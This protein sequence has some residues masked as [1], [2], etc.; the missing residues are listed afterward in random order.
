MTKKPLDKVTDAYK[1]LKGDDFAEKTQN[2]IHWIL[3][4]VRGSD[5]LDIGCSQGIV[6]ILLGREGKKVD[7]IDIAEESIEYALADLKK[8]HESVQ[9]NISFR[10]ANFATEELAGKAYDTILLTEVLEHFADPESL[11]DKVHMHLKENGA[12][13][14]TVPFGINDYY[15]HK[16]TYY[17]SGLEGQLSRL[18]LI[19]KVEYLGEWAGIVCRKDTNCKQ[20]DGSISREELIRLEQAFETKERKLLDRINHLRQT[21]DKQDKEISEWKSLY[22]HSIE[23]MGR[24]LTHIDEGVRKMESLPHLLEERRE[25]T[26]EFD[27][28]R[29]TM[30]ILRSELEAS[31][32]NEERLLQAQ[33]SSLKQAGTQGE[34]AADLEKRLR[35]V[36]RKYA[37]LKNSKLGAITLKYWKL[38]KKINGRA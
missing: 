34:T 10:V 22:I 16:R 1:G 29:R 23:T 2:R 17:Y 4:Q 9:E 32:K 3:R 30:D 13:I 15:D 28:L 6:P 7:G 20:E 26:S 12:L 25:D 21:I 11:L 24:Q 19:E 37:S 18:F 5:I 27:R 38:K 35:Q 36:E 33:L 14:V 31:L 8:E